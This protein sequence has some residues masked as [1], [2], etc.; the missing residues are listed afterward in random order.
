MMEKLDFRR[1]Q[2]RDFDKNPRPDIVVNSVNPGYVASDRRNLSSVSRKSR[3]GI[4]LMGAKRSTQ[5]HLVEK[6]LLI[7]AH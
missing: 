7:P 1:I 6:S 2:Q 5:N 4:F 3:P